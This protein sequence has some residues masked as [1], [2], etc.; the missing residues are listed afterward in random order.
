MS[1]ALLNLLNRS[2]YLDIFLYLTTYT[3]AEYSGQSVY[4]QI[5]LLMYSF[6]SV[7][8][9]ETSQLKYSA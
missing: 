9:A 2:N 3:L 6:Q 1:W 5:Q 7:K 8:Y 4:M